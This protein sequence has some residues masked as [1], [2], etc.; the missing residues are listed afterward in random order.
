[1]YISGNGQFRGSGNTTIQDSL[2]WAGGTIGENG[3]TSTMTVFGNA[4]INSGTLQSKTM[5]MKNKIWRNIGALYLD[6]NATFKIDTLAVQTTNLPNNQNIFS[7]YTG[8]NKVENY[9]SIIK[10]NN[11]KNSITYNSSGTLQFNNYNKIVI[12]EGE[13][14]MIGINASFYKD[15]VILCATCILSLTGKVSLPTDYIFKNSTIL[16]NGLLKSAYPAA[17]W[18]FKQNTQVHA[19]IQLDQGIIYDSVGVNLT[20]LYLSGTGQFRGSGNTS[21]QD[22]LFWAGGTIGENGNTSAMTVLGNAQI[23]SGTL[24]SKTMIFKNKIWRNS[25]SLSIYYNGIFRIDTTAILYSNFTTNQTLFTSNN[26]S[27][28]IE[29]YGTINKLDNLSI[30]LSNYN[31]YEKLKFFNHGTLNIEGGE[32]YCIDIK[33]I[34]S[35]GIIYLNNK[36]KL[37]ISSTTNYVPLNIIFNDGSVNGT[38]RLILEGNSKCY[39]KNSIAFDAGIELNSYS[40]EIIDSVGIQPKFVVLKYGTIKPVAS[41]VIQDSLITTGGNIGHTSY[42]GTVY[43]NGFS[44][45][46]NVSINHIT[47]SVNDTVT[48]TNVYIDPLAHLILDTL[49]RCTINHCLSDVLHITGPNTGTTFGRI[50]VY[51]T[52]IK[53]G[54]GKSTIRQAIFEFRGILQVEEGALE[55]NIPNDPTGKQ[56]FEAG[57][58]TISANAKFCVYTFQS[59]TVFSCAAYSIFQNIG[60]I[61]FGSNVTFNI[62]NPG[63]ISGLYSGKGTI[64]S[65]NIINQGVINPGFSPGIMKFNNL[66]NSNIGQVNIEIGAASGPGTNYDQIVVNG[67]LTL[68][69]GILKIELINGYTPTLGTSFTI[70]TQQQLAGTFATLITPN[71][72][73]N[74]GWKVVYNN[75]S[76][77]LIY[78]ARYWKDYDNDGFGSLVQDTLIQTA[79]TPTGFVINSTDCD[80]FDPY[81]YPNSTFTKTYANG[82][83]NDNS[84]WLCGNPSAS[85]DSILI[86]HT[87]DIDNSL[88][89]L[90]ANVIMNNAQLNLLNTSNLSIGSLSHFHSLGLINS[91]IINSDATSSMHVFGILNNTDNSQIN[92]EGLIHI[93]NP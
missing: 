77:V 25:A 22:S 11:V 46:K 47:L 63:P 56:G 93:H 17:N 86:S 29:N 64:T 1:M 61:C 78:S 33:F 41:M 80:D 44:Q 35:R 83:W 66:T 55:L 2:F 10:N 4:Q 68:N 27:G 81:I 82:N 32:L 45:L 72:D 40:A 85:I 90:N 73:P 76:I 34:P 92:N 8:I 62:I 89:N 74:K 65:P 14:S 5:V 16:G 59:I 50:T 48:L 60:E 91:S 58:I 79:I 36:S 42:N 28:T 67:P 19:G 23:N 12:N 24:Q 38:G 15:T 43:V 51:G 49:S 87:I 75:T 9:G 26:T 71:T 57:E 52:L 21:I 18:Y 3:N 70:F 84:V 69:G 37:R 6:K 39:F 13:L 54:C 31:A 30:L 7:S 53:K 88:I 20:Y